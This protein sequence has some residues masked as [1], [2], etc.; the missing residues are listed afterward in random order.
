MNEVLRAKLEEFIRRYYQNRLLKGLFYA[1]GLGATYYLV[2]TAA[3]LFGRF[4]GSVRAALFFALL[5]GLLIILIR[6]L[7]LPLFKLAGIGKR[8]SYEDAARIIGRHF[9]EV[10]DK[11]LNT[12]QLQGIDRSDSDLLKASIDQRI[13]QM[14]PVPFKSAIDLGEN[15]KYW[16]LLVAPVLI[17]AL[18]ALSGNWDEFNQSS[19]R[20]AEFNREFVPEAPFSFVL[21]NNDLRIEEGQ[22]LEIILG[23]NGVSLPDESY[24]QVNGR[25][26]RMS[27]REDGRYSYRLSKLSRDLSFRF[28]AAGYLSGIYEVEVIPVPRIRNM[29]VNVVPPAYTRIKPFVTGVKPVLDIPEGSEVTWQLDLDQASE[30]HLIN[31]DN[32]E[33]F[34][35]E[36]ASGF[37]L[38]KRVV[39][40]LDYSV[41]LANEAAS[42]Q[43]IRDHR[44]DVIKDGFP[45]IEVAF[46]RDSLARDRVFIEGSIADDYGFSK[47]EL[48]VEGEGVSL[49]RII[50]I[51]KSVNT[52]GFA[53]LLLLDSLAG[54]ES[55]EL[56]IFLKVW[57]NDGVNGAKSAISDMYRL[58]ILGRKEREKQF[59][60][61]YKNYLSGSDDMQRSQEELERQLSEMQKDLQGKKNL[62]W[63]DKNK[64]KELL[65]KQQELLQKQQEREQKLQELKEKEKELGKENEE[66]KKKEEDIDKITSEDKELEELMKEIEE[67][68]EKLDTERLKEKLEKMQEMNQQNQDAMD[69]KDDLLKDLKF[70][71]DVLEQ[72]QK[73]KELGIKM[74]ELARDVEQDM[75]EGQDKDEEELAR[76]EELEEE[77]KETMDKVDELREQNEKFDKEADEEGLDEQEEQTESEMNESRE[78]LQKQESQPANQNQ[79]KAGE[80]M[81]KMSESLQM[82][83]M[84]MQSKQNQENMETLRQILENLKILSFSIEDLSAA[85]K[86]TGRNDP[87]FRSLLT[88]QKRLMDGTRIIEDSLKALGKRVPELE[89]VVFEEL[90]KIDKNLEEGVQWLE[91]LQSAQ[92][93]ANQQMVMTSANNLALLLD[94]TMQSMMQ[95]QAQMMKGNQNCQKPGGGS[96]KPNMQN[97]RKMQGELGQKMD[98]LKKGKQEGKGKDGERM[99][100]EIVEMISRQEQIRQALEGMMKDMEGQG[101][102]GDLQKAI[103]DMKELERDL[104]DGELDGDYKERLK[105]IDTRLL[106]SEK[107]ELKQKKEERR[108]SESAKDRKQ[109]YEEELEK[110]LKEKGIERENIDR[111]PVNFRLYYRDRTTDYLKSK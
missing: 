27:R 4:P 18:I 20:I 111:V 66:L 36:G 99:S 109:I 23:F 22:D 69:R 44:L 97:L 47:L 101:T 57:D 70:Q 89:Q 82:A 6:Y 34:A 46:T 78:K 26:V 60:E 108:E 1:L 54:D 83:M 80:S 14:Q 25:E 19:R 67:L 5:S 38:R 96:P 21:E 64:L 59:E 42:K 58:R 110:Y 84:N 55:R 95:A 11:L 73:L 75:D 10:D 56:S 53:D 48:I 32:Q 37:F 86:E 74:K 105:N 68:M 41:E 85:S 87:A 51:N 76:Q 93:A 15:K 107:A 88:E 81:E 2:I 31:N 90:A 35:N 30:A 28:Q 106:E 103:E 52:A 3:E 13:A 65:R 12:I 24:I 71:K 63:Q 7:L 61:E 45:D 43:L 91:E 79:Q 16:P 33:P 94:E 72:A 50:S 29:Q 9:P 77:F 104:W 100:K 17:I 102:K 8:L 40:D 39:S 98:Q 92:A 49:Q 62:D